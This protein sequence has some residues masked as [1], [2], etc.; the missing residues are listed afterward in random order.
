MKRMFFINIIVVTAIYFVAVFLVRFA[1]DV[2]I[3]HEIKNIISFIF[4]SIFFT[5]IYGS[6]MWL[7]VKGNIRYI[8][9]DTFNE[10]T[11]GHALTDEVVA[12]LSSSDLFVKK[13]SL[14]YKIA[15]VSTD[16]RAVKFYTNSPLNKWDICGVAYWL[17]NGR[18]KVIIFPL[19]GFSRNA[20]KRLQK[21]L[22]RIKVLL[23]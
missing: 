18:V 13:F 3:Q 11:Y 15:R 20:D 2:L 16:G 19:I 22:N 1:I 8:D 23:A 12:N 14:L 9:S 6:F 10:P 7:I 17:P 4:G 21:E 5:L